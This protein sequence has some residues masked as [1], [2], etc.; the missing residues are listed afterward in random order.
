MGNDRPAHRVERH[1]TVITA[2]VATIAALCS[3]FVSPSS[4]AV[5]A[6]APAPV[7][8]IVDASGSMVRDAGGRSRMAVAQEATR[9][10]ITALPTGT[11][12]GLL[13]F[14]TG[15]GNDDRER[16][17]GCQ[18]VTTLSPL[19]PVDA[20]ALGAA[21][22]GIRASGF[23]PIGPALRKAAAMLPSNGPGSIVLV[24][25]G[26][27]T[28]APPS[29]CE[30]AAQ[31]HR[32]NPLLTIHVVGFGV[33]D[34]EEAQ[35]QMTCIGGVG[36][37]TA[38]SASDPAQLSARLRAAA[39]AQRDGVV[40]AQGL[41]GVRLGM[42][43]AEVRAA[44][45]GARVGTPT[46]S[47]G[48]EVIVVDCG[49]GKVE[50]HDDRVF[51]ITPTDASTGTAEGIAPGDG[52]AAFIRLYGAGQPQPDGSVVFPVTS[53]GQ[54]GYRVETDGTGAIRTV[55]VCRCVAAAQG[56][57][58]STWEI[59]FDGVGPLQIGM[60]LDDARA[61]VPGLTRRSDAVWM[62]TAPSGK[63][64]LSAG[65][66]D[67]QLAVVQVGSSSDVPGDMRQ[68]A[69][70]ARG[71]LLGDST[72]LV[73]DAFPGG[74]TSAASIDQN[75]RYIV[76]DRAGRVLSFRFT[77]VSGIHQDGVASIRVEDGSVTRRTDVRQSFALILP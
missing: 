43:L 52:I 44:V 31:L 39:T 6:D 57:S 61:A 26:V 74:S 41:N 72:G 73:T 65:F 59:G 7:V 9:A 8:L 21:V 24:S 29:S 25:D 40:S 60:T 58:V 35:Q 3:L 66:V 64:L 53:T 47:G 30:V 14:G 27:D 38:V 19:R 45:D 23:T 28:C 11:P 34:D 15:T 67:D 55:V 22:D 54:T 13:V 49:W 42:T 46:T 18:D 71:I 2:V 33:D 20:T 69:P 63:P 56:T 32:A 4:G 62:L 5:A 12:T 10:A 36:G 50:L 37:G 1:R 70:R 17:A 51:S 75:T 76:T 68:I 48:V 77:Y 16:A